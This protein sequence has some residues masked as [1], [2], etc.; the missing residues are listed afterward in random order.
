MKPDKSKYSIIP[1]QQRVEKPWGFE[2]IY[3]PQD[4]P[5]VGKIL[6][7]NAGKRLSLQYH[8][9]KVET[10]CLIEGEGMITIMDEKGEMQEIPM[11]KDGGYFIRPC[12][13]HRVRAVSDITFI[14]S[15][16]PE[17]GNT[18]R[19]ED[20]NKRQTETERSRMQERGWESKK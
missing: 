6:H 13:V 3:T 17:T 7:V 4:A 1:C 10:L 15:S 5:A 11:E 2:I 19:M 9:K 18:F 16:T 20:D 8:D 14:E 12:Q